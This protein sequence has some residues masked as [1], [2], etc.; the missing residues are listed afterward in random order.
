MNV[1]QL[2]AALQAGLKAGELRETDGV[3]VF[4]ECHTLSTVDSV[5]PNGRALQINTSG[6]LEDRAEREERLKHA[7]TYDSSE[8]PGRTTPGPLRDWAPIPDYRA[9]R[10]EDDA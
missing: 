6:A 7:A 5:C 1:K 2:I 3:L 9:N 8:D 10:D 4:C